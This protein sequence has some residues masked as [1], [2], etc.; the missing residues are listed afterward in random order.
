MWIVAWLVLGLITGFIANRMQGKRG[1]R[2]WFEVLLG[3]AGATIAGF[4]TN[5]AGDIDRSRLD[6]WSLA[7][8]TFGAVLVLA[9]AALDDGPA[10][11]GGT[12]VRSRAKSRPIRR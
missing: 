5:T 11:G 9:I 6:P 10:G 3:T 2:L 1:E 7:A 4:V 8:S 12:L